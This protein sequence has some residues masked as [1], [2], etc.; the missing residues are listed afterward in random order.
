M[1]TRIFRG[2]CI[3]VFV[4]TAHMKTINSLITSPYHTILNLLH[5]IT[6]IITIIIIIMTTKDHLMKATC[7]THLD[8]G[9]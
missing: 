9:A 7:P 2:E 4:T 8:C 3:T 5:T 1:R 6:T